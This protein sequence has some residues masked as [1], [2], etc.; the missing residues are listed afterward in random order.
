MRGLFGHVHAATRRVLGRRGMGEVEAPGQVCCGA[1]HAHAGRLK[2]A[3]ELARRNIEAFERSG[4]QWIAVDSAGCGAAVLDYRHWLS[5]SPAWEERA[6]SL[7]DR[8]RDVTELACG[9]E[10]PLH[11]A[12]SR[13][14]LEGSVGYDAPCHLVHAQ[15]VRDQPV[16]LLAGI[17]GLSVEVLPSARHCCGGA[18]VYGLLRPSLANEVLDPKLEEIRRGRYD[19]LAT[20]NPGCI[21]HIGAG[22][23]RAGIATSVVHPVEL[24]DWAER[25]SGCDWT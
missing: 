18:G 25:K 11:S 15:S 22:L 9:P 6:R 14:G 16:E 12:V 5:D 8:V 24:A 7:A 13:A 10:A 23:S 19:W 3:A 21:M 1:L 2:E 4:A 20:G 17:E